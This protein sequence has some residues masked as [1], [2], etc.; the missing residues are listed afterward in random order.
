MSEKETTIK[1]SENYKTEIVEITD[2][3]RGCNNKIGNYIQHFE[4]EE[5]DI[6]VQLSNGRLTMPITFVQDYKML[7]STLTDEKI[8]KIAETF[9]PNLS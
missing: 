4:T 5:F 1:A 6:V 9:E 3:A 7:P 2:L 8:N